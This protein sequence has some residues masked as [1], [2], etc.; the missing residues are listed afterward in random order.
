MVFIQSPTQWEKI[1]CCTRISNSVNSNVKMFSYK[2][3][4]QAIKKKYY[5]K[6]NITKSGT[7]EEQKL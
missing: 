7:K 6:T 3:T 4:T 1:E 2:V 5:C